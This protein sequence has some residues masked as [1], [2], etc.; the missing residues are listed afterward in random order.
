MS[1]ARTLIIVRHGQS[2]GNAAGEF[3]GTR[4]VPLTML[5]REQARAAGRHL[6]ERGLR[7]DAVFCSTR[8]RTRESAD[9]ILEA[10]GLPRQNVVEAAELDERDYGALTGLTHQAAEA[11]WGAD[12][13]A[14]WRRSFAAAPPDGE[15]LRDTLAR[16]APC[17]I[18][19]ILPAAMRGIALVVAHGNSLRALV[20]AIEGL[21]PDAIEAVELSTGSVRLY[22][23]AADTTIE[24]CDIP[25]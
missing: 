21:S 13:V 14:I 23:L 22:R 6:S 8:S 25:T 7:P 2:T 9:M 20:A 10:I 17:Y 24:A 19:R 1:G 18:T 4:D 5:G 3:T 16:V 12:Q 11:R 15:S